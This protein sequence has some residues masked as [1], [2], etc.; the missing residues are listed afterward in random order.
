MIEQIQEFM[1]EQTAALGHQVDKIRKGSVGSVRDVVAGSADNIKALK[2]PV[3]TLARS[4]VKVTSVSQTAVAS[5][6]E[7]QSDIVT[8]TLTDV[9]LR[10]DRAAKAGNVVDL[11]RDQIELTHATR[12][13]IVDDAQRAVEI[14]KVASRDLKGVATHA[15]E[16]I[17]DT[18]AKK[19]PAAKRTTRKAKR[20]TRKTG[21]RARKAAAAA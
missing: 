9:A 13:R 1:S 7:L 8:S 10:L 5:F 19:A 14:I 12:G 11:V 2:A 3:R 18:G 20:A 17:T 16:Q 4:G 6:I 21:T 15:Y